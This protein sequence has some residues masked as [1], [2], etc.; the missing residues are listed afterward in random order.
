MSIESHRFIVP[1]EAELLTAEIYVVSY[2]DKD[3]KQGYGVGTHGDM[4]MTSYLGLL[5]V[6]QQD[7]LDWRKND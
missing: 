7:I 4:S 2:V 6:A 1:D 5:Q 3:G